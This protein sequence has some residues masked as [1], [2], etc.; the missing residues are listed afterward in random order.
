MVCGYGDDRHT[1]NRK[2][3]RTTSS[4]RYDIE[5]LLPHR[6]I[7]ESHVPVTRTV[8]ETTDSVL[9]HNPNLALIV[10]D[11]G[12]VAI[13]AASPGMKFYMSY[14]IPVK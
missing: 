8:D 14:N 2:Q 9:H 12:D 3:T 13:L 7:D 4:D 1:R 6:A 11:S 5:A 10:P